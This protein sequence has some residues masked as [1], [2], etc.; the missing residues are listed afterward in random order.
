MEI[1]GKLIQKMPVQSGQSNNGKDWIRGGFVIET[2]DEYPKKIAFQMFGQEKVD[3]VNQLQIN[4]IVQV[5]FSIES[6]E[7]P[8]GS[9]K[10]FTNA[11]CFSVFT[12]LQQSN[13]YSKPKTKP[14][15]KAKTITGN[16]PTPFSVNSAPAPMS[17][18]DNLPF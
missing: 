2:M 9:G 15:P 10:W 11:N 18:D 4:Q 8:I 1:E 17:E 7:Y 14:Q 16:S 3:L 5:K 13:Q 6:R 12:Q